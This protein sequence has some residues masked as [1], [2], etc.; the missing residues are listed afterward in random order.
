M[1]YTTYTT[2]TRCLRTTV[3]SHSSRMCFQKLWTM[4]SA[5]GKSLVTR[6]PWFV[7]FFLSCHPLGPCFIW[8]FLGKKKRKNER[9]V[10]ACSGEKWR[11][12]SFLIFCVCYLWHGLPHAEWNTGRRFNPDRE[13]QQTKN[14]NGPIIIERHLFL[15]SIGHI[16]DRKEYGKE[17]REKTLQGYIFSVCFLILV[18]LFLFMIYGIK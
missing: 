6:R 18:F 2:S 8:Y 7:F 10:I 16:S 12:S 1:S 3:D 14:I 9:K 4:D 11:L 15:L 17:S 13:P 5:K